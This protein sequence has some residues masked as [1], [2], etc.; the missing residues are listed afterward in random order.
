[1]SD[2]AWIVDDEVSRR[3]PI[4]TRGNIGEVFPDVVSPLSWSAYGGEAE[5]GWR[6]AWRDYGVVLDRDL[7]GEDKVILGCF[8]GYCYLN[9]SYIRVFAVRTPGISVEDMDRQFFGES[10]APPYRPQPGDKSAAASLRVARTLL[11]TLS[12]KELPTLEDDKARV[13]AWLAVLPAPASA[14]DQVLLEIVEGFQPL[15][16]HLFRRHIYTT[17]QVSVG[18]G[19]LGQ[20]CEGKLGDAALPNKLLAGIGSVESA[21]PSV[22]MW[23]LGR[24]AASSPAVTA[25]FDAGVDGAEARL[26]AEPE[27]A[28]FREAFAAFVDEFGSRGPNEW[29]GSS[30]TWGTAPRLALAAIDRMRIADP[31]HDPRASAGTPRRRT[32][33]GHGV[34]ARPAPKRGPFPVRPGPA[35]GAGLLARTGKEQDHRHPRPPRPAAGPARAGPP[36]A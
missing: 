4:Y 30:P 9:V 29:E 1:M 10:E 13:R 17:F 12:T 3:F 22:A 20:I 5:E 8:G 7:E 15:F 24:H 28:A 33:G 36:G 23:R 19:L 25:V 32:R 27:A 26:S 16:R 6:E 2:P 11:R 18:A 14:T 35:L 31:S 34:G 21:A